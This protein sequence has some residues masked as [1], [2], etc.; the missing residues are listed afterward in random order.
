MNTY[1]IICRMCPQD[2]H[3]P[4]VTHTF[5]SLDGDTA[6]TFA[7]ERIGNSK[8][9][10]IEVKVSDSWEVLH[11]ITTLVVT[12]VPRP[13][14]EAIPP[15]EPPPPPTYAKPKR[16]VKSL[17]T[18]PIP[19]PEGIAQ[20][21]LC[22]AYMEHGEC[23]EHKDHVLPFQEE[24]VYDMCVMDNVLLG[25]EMGLGKTIEAILYANLMDFW[26]NGRILVVCP[27]SL[28]INWFDEIKKW[29]VGANTEVDP[30]DVF[31]VTQL[32]IPGSSFTIASY[33]GVR[34]WGPLLQNEPW[35]LM[36][37]DE[38]HFCKTPSALRTRA[39]FAVNAKKLIFMSGTPILNFPK[40]L[41]PLIN[42]LD[43][44]VW[45]N[46]PYFENRYCYGPDGKY[47]RNLAELQ[48]KLRGEWKYPTWWDGRK[49]HPAIHRG[50][51]EMDEVPKLMIRRLKQDVLHML[52][53]KRRQV[54]KIPAEGK[55]AELVKMEQMLY[56]STEGKGA[57]MEIL[58]SLNI[59]KDGGENDE[60][61][62]EV[63][64][65][66][67]VTRSYLFQE[68]SRIRHQ[69]ALAKVPTVI[70]HLEN[71]LDNKDKVVVFCHHKDVAKQLRDGALTIL[72][73]TN[74]GAYVVMATG[75]ENI[76]ERAEAVQKFQNDEKCRVF[77]GTLKAAGVGI[78]LTA[79]NH[80][81]FCEMDWT[82]STLTQ[83]EDR[84]HR[85]GQ[86]HSL[87]I[88]HLVVDGSMDAFM[89]DK[90]I[91]KQRSISK[92]LNRTKTKG[93]WK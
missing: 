13:L 30:S 52:P 7:K 53:S 56:A 26:K 4:H 67:T 61:F 47:G 31:C 50:A 90:I 2:N 74:G 91:R 59:L 64:M 41:F 82:P 54:I 39:T 5:Q 3:S 69:L 79:A 58:Q 55:M 22:P 28:I 27:N 16:S 76:S 12:H 57:Y 80:I 81:I 36:I 11:E 25:D 71:V 24:A 37:V 45:D 42:R 21:T 43:S 9:L 66:L 73:K 44:E 35:D 46:V 23:T 19:L 20:A 88:Q 89:A 40:E 65:A 68:I 29:S 17:I 85:I 75:D 14:K 38:A 1:R 51:F 34:K 92:A 78:T 10:V 18:N 77:I 62:A 32:W 93:D 60:E 6:L 72:E 48:A 15:P 63:L 8:Y 87:L 49:G 83:A 86:E 84:C 70:E 33:E